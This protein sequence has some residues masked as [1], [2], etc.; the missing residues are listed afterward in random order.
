MIDLEA[1][2]DRVD[3]PD[4]PKFA[5]V[6]Y[7]GQY[8]GN[9][10]GRDGAVIAYYDHRGVDM[11]GGGETVD[12]ALAWMREQHRARIT[13][14]VR[15][16]V[17]IDEPC[18]RDDLP[19]AVYHSDP[20]R[21][22]SL[23]HSMAKTLLEEGGPAKFAYARTAPRAYKA[24]FSLGTV[25]HALVLGKGSDVVDVI[26]ADNWRSKAAQT[27]RDASLAKGRV[28]ILPHQ[29][30][31]AEDMA[32][33]L[34]A[35]PRAHDLLTGGRPE[36]SLFS[37]H[38]SG[39]WLRGQVDY[40]TDAHIGDYKSTA[41][42]T[43]RGFNRSVWSFRYYLQDAWYRRMARDL[44]GEEFDYLLIVQESEPPYLPAVFAL[45]DDY[46][47]LGDLHMDRAIDLYLSCT[48]SG[49]WPGY[50]DEIQTLSP[51]LYARDELLAREA[52]DVI[53]AL[54]ALLEK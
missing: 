33:A 41:D 27:A 39:L 51:P 50:P 32:A 38:P 1:R 31:T 12:A 24:E 42:G 15:D 47:R 43:S 10:R 53:A 30:T 23:S 11:I 19:A 34:A 3:L 36:V 4:D 25:A 28:P 52:G 29:M 46:R 17:I 2:G 48:A 37:V 49:I 35:S 13:G 16:P 26:T 18:I 54:E 8:V 9:L 21:H 22:G 6:T 5:T 20:T 40:M 44:T 14:E 7:R 45:D